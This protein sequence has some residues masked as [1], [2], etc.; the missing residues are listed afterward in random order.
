MNQKRGHITSNSQNKFVGGR[1]PR[2]PLPNAN[3]A[4]NMSD[5]NRIQR[6]AGGSVNRQLGKAK[7]NIAK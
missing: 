6:A 7:T 1:N 3:Q 2:A 4:Q 5:R